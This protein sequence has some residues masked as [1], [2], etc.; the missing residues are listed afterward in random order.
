LPKNLLLAMF[1]EFNVAQQA[2]LKPAVF[3]GDYVPSAKVK[4]ERWPDLTFVLQGEGQKDIELRVPPRDYWQLD[5]DKVGSAVSGLM[6]SGD[7]SAILGLPLMNGY[8]TIF[9]GEADHG[10]GAVKFATAIRD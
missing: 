3:D 1:A 9:D 5:A 2:L 8:F 7:N 4:R 6:V 10:K